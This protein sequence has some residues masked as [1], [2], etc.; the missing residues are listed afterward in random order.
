VILERLSN[1]ECPMS[2]G[3]FRFSMRLLPSLIAGV[4]HWTPQTGP[5]VL[6]QIQLKSHSSL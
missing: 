6:R 3:F 2:T 1:R 5:A 4:P